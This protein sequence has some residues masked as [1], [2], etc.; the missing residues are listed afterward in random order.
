MNV[1]KIFE[2]GRLVKEHRK[3]ARLTQ[4]QLAEFAGIGKTAVFDIEHDKATVQMQTIL[5]VFD[6]L[7]IEMKLI[8]PECVPEV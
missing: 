4:K 3:M 5:R 2:I 8:P 6:V 7:N 1:K